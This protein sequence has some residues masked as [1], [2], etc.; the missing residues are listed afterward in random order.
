M[1][2]YSRASPCCFAIAVIY[3]ARFNARHP[4]LELTSRT[5]QRLLLVATMLATKFYEDNF[6]LNSTWCGESSLYLFI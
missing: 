4:S 6:F 2:K 5:V 1:S 3:L